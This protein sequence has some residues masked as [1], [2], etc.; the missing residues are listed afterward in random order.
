MIAAKIEDCLNDKNK[1]AFVSLN[2]ERI[3]GTLKK[4]SCVAEIVAEVKPQQ[5]TSQRNSVVLPEDSVQRRHYLTNIRAIIESKHPSC[6]TDSALKR[7]YKT[8]IDAEIELYL[9]DLAS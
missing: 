6:P 2:Y 1:M 3:K 7:H 5:Q 9:L 4:K 8:M